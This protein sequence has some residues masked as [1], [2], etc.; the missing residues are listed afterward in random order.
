MD[1]AQKGGLGLR[2]KPPKAKAVSKYFCGFILAAALAVALAAAA[3]R[4]APPAAKP[5]DTGD[6]FY[7]AQL[8][9]GG[10]GDWYDNRASMPR[11][12]ERLAR[13]FGV[14]PG[15]ERK[16]VRLADDDLFSYPVIFMS[17]HGNVSFAPEEVA[18]LRAYF[19]RGGFLWAS[20]DYGMA[21]S[22]R[23]ELKKVLP[24][25]DYVELPFSHP[26]YQ[27]PYRFPSGLPKIH[28]HDGGPPRGYALF[29]G[30]RM[31]F[32]ADINTDIGDGLEA[33]SIH[34]DPPEVQ[35]QAFRMAVNIVYFALSQ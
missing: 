1:I 33:P 30:D 32:F 28:E 12:Q 4:A 6:K 10:G 15:A 18:R 13:E 25:Q 26:I 34:N 2:P 17:G 5:S 29:L 20:D 19:E 8:R 27:A 14:F 11:L 22:L 9:Y 16:I 21:P 23:R 35:E 3:L 7:I 31:V 24:G